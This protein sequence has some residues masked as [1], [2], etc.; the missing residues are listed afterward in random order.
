VTFALGM[1]TGLLLAALNVGVMGMG[2]RGLVFVATV[3]L[4]YAGLLVAIG[5]KR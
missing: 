4:A 5:A 3:N 2:P 1:A